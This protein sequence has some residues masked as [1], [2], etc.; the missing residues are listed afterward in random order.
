MSPSLVSTTM[1]APSDDGLAISDASTVEINAESS[2]LKS[3][4][5]PSADSLPSLVGSSMAWPD[6]ELVSE[7]ASWNIQAPVSSSLHGQFSTTP[8]ELL[9][10]VSLA[11]L[12][13]MSSGSSSVSVPV[14]INAVAQV[15]VGSQDVATTANHSVDFHAAEMKILASSAN[16]LDPAS[17]L[18]SPEAEPLS[19]SSTS[20][21]SSEPSAVNHHSGAIDS[22]SAAVCSVKKVNVSD[23]SGSSHE[24]IPPRVAVCRHG[25][26]ASEASATTR[27][28]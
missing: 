20:H 21:G 8:D 28:S 14:G 25:M 12:P 2:M 27:P 4:D 9:V 15:A 1:A 23:L 19:W 6:D 13:E 17:S 7:S 10:D 3:S 26:H 24:G 18:S 11:A 22:T 5:S 16:D